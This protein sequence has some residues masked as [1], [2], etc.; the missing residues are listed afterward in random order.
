[1]L[2][3]HFN[4]TNGKSCTYNCFSKACSTQLQGDATSS[5]E[6]KDVQFQLTKGTLETMLKS[7]YSVR[8]Q[9]SDDV[10]LAKELGFDSF[11]SL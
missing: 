8:S 3:F 7:M 2:S 9:L 4:V 5:C 10:S 11:L 1:M 6:E